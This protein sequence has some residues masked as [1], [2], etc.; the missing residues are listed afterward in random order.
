MAL[1]IL[2]AV[3]ALP[4]EQSGWPNTTTLAADKHRLKN[5]PR[6]QASIFMKIRFGMVFAFV[7]SVR[8]AR[9]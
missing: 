5:P 9:K 3:A 6:M 7:E 4:Y 1:A 8:R 2:V